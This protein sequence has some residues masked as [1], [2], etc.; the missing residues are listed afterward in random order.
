MGAPPI[1]YGIKLTTWALTLPFLPMRV[2]DVHMFLLPALTF[3]LLLY[4]FAPQK[5]YVPLTNGNIFVIATNLLITGASAALFLHVARDHMKPADSF[6]DIPPVQLLLIPFWI[7]ADEIWFFHAHRFAHRKEVYSWCHK[8]HH[9][10][11]VTSAWTSFYAHPLDHLV[12]VIWG[13]LTTP[14]LTCLYLPG[15]VSAPVVVLF[16]WGGIVTFIGSHHTVKGK[17]GQAVAGD[18]LEHHQ[19]FNVNFGNFGHFDKDRL[20]LTCGDS[21]ETV[22]RAVGE[23]WSEAEKPDLFMVDGLHTYGHALADTIN[24][25]ALSRGGATVA[26]DD[27]DHR[28]F[29]LAW[30]EAVKRGVVEPLHESMCWEK[31]CLGRCL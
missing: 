11:K 30:T 17:G 2:E 24:A 12:C 6:Y 21:V 25:C 14:L 9:L 29:R 20:G 15:G 10:F 7:L 4:H 19:K 5:V 1:H 8:W 27:C 22:P 18:H 13:A 23:G 3:C 26:V 16:M 28:E 31:L